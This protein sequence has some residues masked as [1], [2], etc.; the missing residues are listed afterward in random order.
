MMSKL[1]HI[2]RYDTK[3]LHP[4]EQS[5]LTCHWTHTL[6]STSLHLLAWNWDSALSCNA[7]KVSLEIILKITLISERNIYSM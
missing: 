1:L 2:S 6:E 7:N 3:C 5:Y 4:Q